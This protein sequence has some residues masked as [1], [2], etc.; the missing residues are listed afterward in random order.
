MFSEFFL[1]GLTYTSR[2]PIPLHIAPF[3]Y[4]GTICLTIHI[5]YEQHEGLDSY[6]GFV[7]S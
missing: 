7:I 1:S 6:D 5:G 2:I 3:Q 4:N